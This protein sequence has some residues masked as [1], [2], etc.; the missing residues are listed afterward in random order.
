MGGLKAC[1]S[2]KAG[3]NDSTFLLESTFS[4][5]QPLR[6]FQAL[7]Y[8]HYEPKGQTDIATK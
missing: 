2:G 3:S 7:E 6:L 8:N 1:K 5:V 4:G